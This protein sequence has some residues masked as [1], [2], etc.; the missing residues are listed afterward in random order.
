MGTKY[1]NYAEREK[2]NKDLKHMEEQ[3]ANPYVY[4][5]LD[6]PPA[7]EKK[8]VQLRH[9]VEKKTPPPVKD[10]K[11]RKTLQSRLNDLEAFITLESSD[12][13]KPSMPSEY[14]QEK[15]PAGAVG[16]HLQWEH[17]ITHNNVDG[18][19][20]VVRNPGYSA[21]DERKDI[22]RRLDPEAEEFDPEYT[23]IEKIRP[24]E[25]P[26]SS[27]SDYRKMSFAQGAGI[28]QEKWDEAVGPRPDPKAESR[29]RSSERMKERWAK[30]RAAAA[31]AETSE[32]ATA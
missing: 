7:F 24:K 22:M 2:L 17:S 20:N 32:A 11:E 27:F 4:G 10:D 23:S 5:G 31:A 6:D 13:R 19:G 21:F 12:V 28:S 29:R 26:N 3:K 9:E 18:N 14:Q 25:K 8:L 16:Q 15:N 1:A 30:K